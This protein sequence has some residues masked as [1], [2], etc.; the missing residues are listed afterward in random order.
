M[1]EPNTP[2]TLLPLPHRE[3][4][5]GGSAGWYESSLLSDLSPTS[6]TKQEQSPTSL[7]TPASREE[8]STHSPLGPRERVKSLMRMKKVMNSQVERQPEGEDKKK[9]IDPE[10]PSTPK[11]AEETVHQKTYP[12]ETA[13]KSRLSI[14]VP[15]SK[16]RK[17][18]KWTFLEPSPLLQEQW[19][20]SA[21]REAHPGTD[22]PPLTA[23]S[24]KHRKS[25]RF[26]R[27]VVEKLLKPDEPLPSPEEDLESGQSEVAKKRPTHEMQPLER[28][29]EA[30]LLLLPMLGAMYMLG[31]SCM[32]NQ[33]WRERL[34]IVRLTLASGKGEEKS[35][36]ELLLS[37]WG[38][39]VKQT[40]GESQ[41]S[42][43]KLLYTMDSFFSIS[44]FRTKGF[45]E[46]TFNP[47]TMKAFVVLLATLLST[48]AFW[49]I[50]QIFKSQVSKRLGSGM[51]LENGTIPVLALASI[52]L[53]AIAL[54]ASVIPVWLG[55]LRR[56]YL[57]HRNDSPIIRS[58]TNEDIKKNDPSVDEKQVE[59]DS[60]DHVG[61]GT[62][63]QK[64]KNRLTI[65]GKRITKFL[66]SSAIQRE[67]EDG[68]NFETQIDLKSESRIEETR[69]DVDAEVTSP[70]TKGRSR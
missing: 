3:T 17:S 1:R 5:H 15:G 52:I 60:E 12:K 62:T 61:A 39:C 42:E 50:R 45:G 34:S 2:T 51:N 64:T 67:G 33:W 10:P 14:T 18:S 25:N 44:A 66:G 38:W 30:S 32:P 6:P 28:A 11:G 13:E 27:L 58:N 4:H 7:Q 19:T 31:S 68:S 37:L 70:V 8:A 24:A 23:T 35:G 22:S 16:S 9:R 55:S 29:V 21:S 46:E 69:G 48:C 26:T 53:L 43:P 40:N 20:P 47:T 59:G 65:L 56:Q 41:C 57:Y 54:S 63:D 49:G 36:P